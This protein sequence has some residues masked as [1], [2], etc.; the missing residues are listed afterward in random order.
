MD[1]KEETIDTYN[2]GI[3]SFAKKFKERFDL[4]R[5]KEFQIFIQNLKGNKILDLG[6]GAGDHALYFKQQ[7]LEVTAIDLSDEM[8]EL[9]KEKGIN[10]IKMDIEDLKFNPNTFDGIWA[11]SSLLHVPKKELPKVIE[12][13]KII[14]KEKGVLFIGVFEGEGEDNRE[15]KFGRR[16]FSYWKED[17]L[18]SM[19]EK[20]F[21]LISF[22]RASREERVFLHFT[23]RKK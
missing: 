15:G 1:Y 6:C 19:L 11:A 20:D 4:K 13:L 14:L 10:A 2:K 5:R 7:D 16:F 23:F 22:H 3:E 9:T 12:T 8:L 21:D 18:I 17:E